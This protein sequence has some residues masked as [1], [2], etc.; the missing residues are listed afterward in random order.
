[1]SQ[2]TPILRYT[3]LLLL[4]GVLLTSCAPTGISVQPTA[5]GG[6]AAQPAITVTQTQPTPSLVPPTESV[7]TASPSAPP[8][9]A[10]TATDATEEMQV[11]I[12]HTNDSR[13][14]VDPCG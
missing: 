6:Q 11:T 3:T 14:Y 2:R 4:L 5:S 8:A 1:M 10:T 7:A 9:T 12:L 13:G